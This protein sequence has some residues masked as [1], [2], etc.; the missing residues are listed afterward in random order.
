M[1][2]SFRVYLVNDGK[3]LSG[4]PVSDPYKSRPK[5]TVDQSDLSVEE[6]R[7]NHV[8]RVDNAS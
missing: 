5:P 8:G 7:R 2:A 3:A 6:A 1:R 4:K